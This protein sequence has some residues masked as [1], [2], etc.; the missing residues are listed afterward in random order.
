MKAIPLY[1]L[2]EV[3]KFVTD[4]REI[5]SFIASFIQNIA[6][7]S[8][9]DVL[10]S[11]LKNENEDCLKKTKK[12]KM[13]LSMYGVHAIQKDVDKLYEVLKKHSNFQTVL[14]IIND[15]KLHLRQVKKQMLEDFKMVITLVH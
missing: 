1:D 4:H 14:P 11:Y 8:C 13:S 6:E 5:P 12:L 7:G 2:K 9:N 15:I 3:Q 10:S